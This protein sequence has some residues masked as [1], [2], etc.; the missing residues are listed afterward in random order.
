LK[1]VQLKALCKEYGL[2]VSGK[3]SDLQERL[4]EHLLSSVEDENSNNDLEEMTDDDLRDALIARGISSAGSRKQ[5]LDRLKADIDFTAGVMATSDPTNQDGYA[6]ISQALE[7]AAKKE[8]GAISEML[9]ELKEKSE[10]V[11]KFVDVT[12]RSLGLTPEK[13]TAGGAP[14]A[15]ADVLRKLA[16]DP[17]ADPPKYGS[18]RRRKNL[19]QS[20]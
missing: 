4:R 12:V 10:K 19:F 16:G 13:Y 8:G 3:K 9:N 18:V 6:A 11:P 2:K 20:L 17:F 7:E 15:T 14:S 5:I 1:V